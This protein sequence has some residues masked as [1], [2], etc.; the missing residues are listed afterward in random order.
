MVATP[1]SAQNVHLEI[2]PPANQSAL[3]AFITS[4]TSQTSNTMMT[5]TNSGSNTTEISDVYQIYAQLCTPS[6]FENGS[7]V[8]FVVHGCVE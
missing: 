1:V 3:T 5:D 8:E 7:D 6:T 2:T 4:Y